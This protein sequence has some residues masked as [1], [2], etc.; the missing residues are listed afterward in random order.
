MRRRALLTLLPLVAGLPAVPGEAA[1]LPIQPGAYVSTKGAGCTLNFLFTD[2]KKRRYVGTAGH[3]SA[4]V[5]D[6]S[7]DADDERI[8]TIVFR[9]NDGEMDFS[10]IAVD[11]ARY[12]D[13]KATVLG[14]GG[15]TGVTK[16]ADT[17]QLDVVL[18]YGHGL[19]YGSNEATRPRR[20]VLVLDDAERYVVNTPVIFGDSGGPVLHAPTGRALGVISR[21][22]TDP[23]STLVGPTVESILKRLAQ[24]GF[25]LTLTT[26]PYTPAVLAHSGSMVG[27]SAP[28]P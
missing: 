10:L 17:A 4:K 2:V 7:L 20:G 15:P 9:E 5:G 12:G 28:V 3:C 11:R 19:L 25:K 18:H 6:V 14:W 8:G 24:Q 26:A 22:S 1:G 27:S 23:P 16:P 13:L 21:L